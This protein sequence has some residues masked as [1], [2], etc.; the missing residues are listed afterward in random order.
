MT[1]HT[2]RDW[3]ADNYEAAAFAPTDPDERATYA[4]QLAHE[5]EHGP[6]DDPH[7]P[8]GVKPA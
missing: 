7:D 5:A 2:D 4:A 8:Q 1:R 6:A 3:F